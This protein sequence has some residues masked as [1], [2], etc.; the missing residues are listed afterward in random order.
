MD[1]GSVFRLL[2]KLLAGC[3]PFLPAECDVDGRMRAFLRLAFPSVV[4][5]RDAHLT[6][7]FAWKRQKDGRELLPRPRVFLCEHFIRFRQVAVAVAV[8]VQRLTV[9]HQQ[10]RVFASG[11]KTSRQYFGLDL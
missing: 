6:T 4:M 1:D 8:H 7:F 2:G 3:G 9:E 5:N 11:P 10:T